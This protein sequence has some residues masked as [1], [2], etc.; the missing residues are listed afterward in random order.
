MGSHHQA[1]CPCGFETSVSVGG[2][3]ATYIHTSYFPFYCKEHG[4][5]SVNYRGAIECTFCGSKDIQQY[6]EEPISIKTDE[7]WPTLQS[8]DYKAYSKGNLCPECKQF[9][10]V[11]EGANILTD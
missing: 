5:I 8:F 4:L 7:R 10:M 6:G 2:N 1:I 3:Q 9:T 11:F